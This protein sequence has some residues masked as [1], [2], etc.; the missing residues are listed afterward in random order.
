MLEKTGPLMNTVPAK[1]DLLSNT[2]DLTPFS[3]KLGVGKEGLRQ[4]QESLNFEIGKEVG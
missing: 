1:P 2:P 4:F 3:W